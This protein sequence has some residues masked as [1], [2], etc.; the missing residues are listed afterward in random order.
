MDLSDFGLVPHH[1]KTVSVGDKI[2]RLTVLAI[3]KVPGT[4]KYRL[5]V[6]CDCGTGPYSANLGAIQTSANKS[7]GCL[8]RESAT[9]HG[10][11]KHPLYAKWASMHKR[12]YNRKEARYNRYGGR[13]ISVCERWHALE[14]F[15]ADMEPTYIAGMELDRID[16]DG[17]YEPSN[18]RW[19]THMEQANNKS[20]VPLITF[21]GKTL[22]LA[23]WS[24]ET[25]INYG[26]LRERVLKLGWSTERA[27]TSPPMSA[28]ERCALARSAR[29]C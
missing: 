5:V 26:T 11:H 24:V 6:K 27:L 25:G 7:C 8:Q 28:D 23:Q 20:N 2:H 9:T 19:L 4:Y 14:N 1:C 18:C 10:L 12:C 13:G 21:A 22:S 3:G 29:P 16:Y 15:L 17:N